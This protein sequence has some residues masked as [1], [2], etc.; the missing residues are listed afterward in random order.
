LWFAVVFAGGV[1]GVL[2]VVLV[3]VR[4]RV[5]LWGMFGLVSGQWVVVWRVLSVVFVL[6]AGWEWLSLES[7][8]EKWLD[9]L[10]PGVAVFWLRRGMQ[11]GSGIGW[12][13]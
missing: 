11:P 1:G 5:E 9:V 6:E 3:L 4:W 2:R 12:V 8:E 7:L 13:G 10:L